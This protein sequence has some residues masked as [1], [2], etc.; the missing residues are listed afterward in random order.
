LRCRRW[1]LARAQPASEN[2][3]TPIIELIPVFLLPQG[4]KRVNFGLI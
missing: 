3:K 4:G 2:E 1:P